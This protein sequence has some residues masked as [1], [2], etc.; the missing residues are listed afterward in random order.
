MFES[1]E[2]HPQKLAKK[3]LLH[4]AQ[5]YKKKQ[6]RGA[7]LLEIIICLPV[8]LMMMWLFL[9]VGIM[10]NARSS[11][12]SAMENSLR[13]ALTR[14]NLSLS[15]ADEESLYQYLDTLCSSL[16]GSGRNALEPILF[17]NQKEEAGIDEYNRNT[18]HWK[19]WYQSG[20]GAL[21]CEQ[22]LHNIY[23]IVFIQ[24]TMQ[25]SVGNSVKFPCDPRS[26]DKDAGA[27]CMRCIP[28]NPCS[29]DRSLVKS[30]CD[31]STIFHR[32][33]IECEFRPDSVFVAPFDALANLVTGSNTNT[34]SVISHRAFFETPLDINW[35][36]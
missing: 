22:P 19:D 2:A 17:A 32:V 16:S 12:V 25:N 1:K 28:L 10:Y 9:Y 30:S 29:L 7:A 6:L 14:S 23:A 21:F 8:L 26:D 31:Q 24:L 13:V 20:E 27:G 5:D 35:N 11:L 15:M 18:A 3:K 4:R 36:Q 34:L 33:A